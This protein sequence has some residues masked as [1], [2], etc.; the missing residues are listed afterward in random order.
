M[1][2][3]FIVKSILLGALWPVPWELVALTGM[4]QAG[5]IGDKYVQSETK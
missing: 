5:Y 1:L 2:F 4:S 3:L